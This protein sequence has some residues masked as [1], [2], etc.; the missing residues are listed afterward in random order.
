MCH[1]ELPT[2]G[3]HSNHVQTAAVAYGDTSVDTTGGLY[4]FGCGNCHPVDEGTYH[5]D[6][7]VDITMNSG[8]G[9]ALKAMNNVSDDVSGYSQT[10]GSSV[11]CSAAYCHSKGNGTFDVTSPDW[12]AVFAG[13][14]CGHCHG[15]SP[16]TSSHGKHVVGIHYL[17]IYTGT[18]G[19]A[20][21][22]STNTSSHGH[23]ATST[24][25]NCS[26]CH[27][28]TVDQAANSA[29]TVCT[30]CH[31]DN[32]DAAVGDEVAAIKA[33]S[34]THLNASVDVAFQGVQVRSKAQVR[35]DITTVTELNTS[36]TR[37]SG[38]KAA[39]SNDQAN[40]ALNTGTM[41][42][43]E[44]RTC[45]TIACHNGNSITWGAKGIGCN[46]CHN[47]LP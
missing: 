16:S 14:T 30:A 41:F 15:N 46:S 21:E 6:G 35:D 33:G 27:N 18:T 45:S 7:S 37:I 44:T 28:N 24:T 26:T 4:D 43:S 40:N 36:W 13:D 5:R 11:T 39:G 32:N 17:D 38:Y 1:D 22:G 12:Y 47:E 23:S 8:H 19:L 2:S 29:N 20:T 42:N 3:A 25:I 10:P 31:V 34:V 9:G